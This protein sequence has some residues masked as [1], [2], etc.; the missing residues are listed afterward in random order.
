M[1]VQKSMGDVTQAL[2][3]FIKQSMGG[4]CSPNLSFVLI[5]NLLHFNVTISSNHIS[6]Q[7]TLTPRF[8]HLLSL[9]AQCKYTLG[10]IGS[11]FRL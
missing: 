5:H 1:A 10:S 7:I 6:S 9:V 11:G 4:T 3:V 8:I 2:S